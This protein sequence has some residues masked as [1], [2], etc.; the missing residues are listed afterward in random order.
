[1]SG[2][3]PVSRWPGAVLPVL[4]MVGEYLHGRLCTENTVSTYKVRGPLKL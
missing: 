3:L 2:Q 4:V 1:M